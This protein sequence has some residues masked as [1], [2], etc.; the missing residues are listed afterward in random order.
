L[1]SANSPAPDS[2][3]IAVSALTPAQ[4]KMPASFPPLETF[5]QPRT[6]W[7]T[8]ICI[9]V[10][11][12]IVSGAVAWRLPRKNPPP[13]PAPTV[14]VPTVVHH[15]VSSAAR[16][17]AKA[18]A[19]APGLP[20]FVPAA[21]RDSAYAARNPG[22][23]RYAGPE[24]ECRLFRENNRIRAVQLLPGNRPGLDAALL[25]NVLAELA[26]DAHYLVAARE[27]AKGYRILRGSIPGKADLMLYYRGAKLHAFVVS[28]N[29]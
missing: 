10:V 1:S 23:E 2:F 9:A 8:T 4:Q 18:V 14:A 28:L 21:G 26:G 15:A 12:A 29:E 3:G 25:N 19:P 22:W 27:N 20:A 17:V 6:K 11:L 24:Y 16:P 13:A 5:Q 7:R